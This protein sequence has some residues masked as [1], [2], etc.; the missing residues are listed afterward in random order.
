MWQDAAVFLPQDGNFTSTGVVKV[1]DTVP[2]IGLQ[3]FFL[4]TATKDFSMGPRSLFPAANDPQVFLSAWTGDLGLDRGIPQSVYRLDTTSMKRLGIEELS[5]GETWKLP[6]GRG[7]VSFTGYKQWA[8]F[9]ITHD[10]GKG[11]ALVSAFLAIIGLSLSLLVPRRRVWLRI[12]KQGDG[13]NLFE[14]AGLSKTEAPGLLEEVERLAMQVRVS[15][16]EVQ[17]VD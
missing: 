12:T 10:P 2:Q 5:P 7:T 1:P 4:P 17:R 16:G 15:A 9:S 11:W 14:V 6:Q 8:S 3:G 13:S